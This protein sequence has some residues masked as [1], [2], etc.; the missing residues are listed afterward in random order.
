MGVCVCVYILEVKAK[1]K[2]SF[3]IYFASVASHKLK[4]GHRIFI[5]I[6]LET[7][8]H[9]FPSHYLPRV[10]IDNVLPSFKSA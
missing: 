8:M 10:G 2:T 3:T 7:L 9:L 5:R 4:A 1:Q 6:P